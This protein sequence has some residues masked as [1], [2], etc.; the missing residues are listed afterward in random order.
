[1]GLATSSMPGK[2]LTNLKGKAIADARNVAPPELGAACISKRITAN[3]KGKATAAPNNGATTKTGRTTMVVNLFHVF[4]PSNIGKRK[5]IQKH[6]ETTRLSLI[7]Y[8]KAVDKKYNESLYE[9]N[10]WKVVG[11]SNGL[12]C[13][14]RI[15]LDALTVLFNPWT[16]EVTK[17]PIAHLLPVKVSRL[18]TLSFGYDSYSDDYKPGIFYNVAL[19]WYVFHNAYKVILSFDLSREEFTVFPEPNDKRYDSS[20]TTPD[21]LEDHLCIFP[22]DIH[23]DNDP[24]SDIWVAEGECP[25]VPTKR[26]KF[27]KA[28]EEEKRAIKE[29]YKREVRE[30]ENLYLHEDGETKIEIKDRGS[31]TI[32]LC[33]ERG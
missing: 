24:S 11:S 7:K 26:R 15:R 10:L 27:V 14:F 13:F 8:S 30:T 25:H 22:L 3:L 31:H 32:P 16:R 19:H 17:L 18:L 21:M 9:Y 1:M 28:D 6:G 23:N 12:V 33:A 5:T 29:F 20:F 2:R 4:F